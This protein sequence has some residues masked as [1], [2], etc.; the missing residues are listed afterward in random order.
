[1]PAFCFSMHMH[2]RV[3][4]LNTFSDKVLSIKT[5]HYRH[6]ERHNTYQIIMYP[7]LLLSV[8]GRLSG[9]V[10]TGVGVGGM[11]GWKWDKVGEASRKHKPGDTQWSCDPSRSGE[12]T[13][14]QEGNV[15]QQVDADCWMCCVGTA[16]VRDNVTNKLPGLKGGGRKRETPYLCFSRRAQ[17]GQANNAQQSLMADNR[18]G[19]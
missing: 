4:H 10:R 17:I 16:G 13:G 11:G 12:A 8:S 14:K 9:G 15:S 1:M 5:K 7:C 2:F 18:G 3:C 19:Q 6:A